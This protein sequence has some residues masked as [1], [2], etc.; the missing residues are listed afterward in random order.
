MPRWYEAAVDSA[1]KPVAG[2]YVAKLPGRHF[3]GHTQ[4]YLVNEAQKT[5]IVA[6]LWRQRIMM[7]CALPICM[8]LGGVFGR[9]VAMWYLTPGADAV[10]AGGLA[11]MLA[12]LLGVVP[13]GYARNRLRP[14]LATLQ[15]T[16]QGI[17]I[18]EQ[19]D[20]IARRLSARVIL[21]GLF[22]GLGMVLG[23]IIMVSDAIQAQRPPGLPLTFYVFSVG[24]GVA[25]TA[26]FAWLI[27]LRTRMNGDAA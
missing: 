23:G 4:S 14:L 5:Q 19:I 10:P 8:A 9:S 11:L 26:Y 13:V 21:I 3:L 2:G 20:T 27:V 22:Y 7:L 18:R 1:F 25:L 12:L 6:V 16:D 15:T 17:S 24:A